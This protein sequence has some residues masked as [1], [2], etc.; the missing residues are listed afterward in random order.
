MSI[1][2]KLYGG[3][4]KKVPAGTQPG[5]P[6]SGS[7]YYSSFGYYQDLEDGKGP[8]P[9]SQGGPTNLE[10]TQHEGLADEKGMLS[11]GMHSIVSAMYGG[12]IQPVS[13]ENNSMNPNYAAGLQG[14][15]LGGIGN[16]DAYG[17]DILWSTPDPNKGTYGTLGEGDTFQTPAGNYTVTKN[18]WG[19]YVLQPGEG[20]AQSNSPYLTNYTSGGHHI[21]IN[22]QTGEVWYQKA[23]GYYNFSG[24]GDSYTQTDG[25]PVNP[26]SPPDNGGN[27]NGGGNNGPTWQEMLNNNGL[28][29]QFPA[30]Q[31]SQM[32]NRAVNE[33]LFDSLAQADAY[34]RLLE[35]LGLRG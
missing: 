23:S 17:N 33:G 28:A 19:Q 14:D 2:E 29:G 25:A 30:Q 26:N 18:P 5:K 9:A 6:A 32:D 21:G 31:Q 35:N 7:G 11:N 3:G 4:G 12:G 10:I 27:G 13:A 34:K 24:G 15:T 20:A 1:I 22:P 16:T 8:P